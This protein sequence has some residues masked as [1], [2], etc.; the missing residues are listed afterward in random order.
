MIW[1]AIML[2]MIGQALN[3]GTGYWVIWGILIFIKVLGVFVNAVGKNEVDKLEKLIE[4]TL[5]EVKEDLKKE[6]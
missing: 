1:L 2:F 4:E 3:M 5:E 6:K